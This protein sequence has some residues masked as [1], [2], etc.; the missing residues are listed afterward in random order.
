MKVYIA[1]YGGRHS[2]PEK[3]SYMAKY[4]GSAFMLN[5]SVKSEH[6]DIKKDALRVRN[7]IK[8]LWHRV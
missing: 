8:I 3:F 6:V 5:G 1:Q 2:V 7:K 4:D